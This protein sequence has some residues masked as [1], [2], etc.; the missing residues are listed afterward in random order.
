[1]KVNKI[2]HLCDYGIALGPVV[3]GSGAGFPVPHY[4]GDLELGLLRSQT[5]RSNKRVPSPPVRVV[6][7][8]VNNL[9][10]KY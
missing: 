9:E 5:L 4:H 3:D 6:I 10:R 8:F 7:L 1:M 2:T